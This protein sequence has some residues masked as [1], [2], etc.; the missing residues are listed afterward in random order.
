MQHVST[1]RHARKAPL[2]IKQRGRFVHIQSRYG[3]IWQIRR[4][5][6]RSS[7]SSAL[8]G[9]SSVNGTSAVA[10]DHDGSQPESDDS[11]TRQRRIRPGDNAFEKPQPL[12]ENHQPDEERSRAAL[13]N[14]AIPE[15]SRTH[16]QSKVHSRID[17]DLWKECGWGIAAQRRPAGTH[18][19]WSPAQSVIR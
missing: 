7:S 3:L 16:L 1:W 2:S 4:H 9:E 10:A 18:A 12:S 11:A 15:K 8:R 14:S 19:S 6:S 13:P 5:R 17:R